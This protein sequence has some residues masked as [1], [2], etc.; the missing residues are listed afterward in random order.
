[1]KTHQNIT[2]TTQALLDSCDMEYDAKDFISKVLLYSLGIGIGVGLIF[3]NHS[4]EVSVVTGLMMFAGCIL[5]VYFLLL[6]TANKRIAM[7]ED[8]LPDFLNYVA[9]NI[10]SG[11][12]YDRALL[13]S[14]GKEFGPLAKEIDRAAKETLS[15]KT[16]GEALMEMAQRV[17]S[18]MF[19]KTIRLIVE[20]VN[21]GG[22]LA[23][24]LE[25]TS[26]DIRKFSAI[27][28]DVAATV[29]IYQL[30]IFAAAA[31]GA[32]LLYAVATFLVTIV[33]EMKS[34]MDISS[35]S[36]STVSLPFMR[37]GQTSIS[38]DLLFLFSIIAIA[39]T[40]FFGALASG[41]ISKGKE[42]DGLSNVPTIAFVSYAVFFAVRFMLETVVR[43]MLFV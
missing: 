5:S 33:S 30:F 1:M 20:G 4:L 26:S 39:I 42:S 17:D 28:K 23:Q 19:C 7:I 12:T 13:L 32:P 37:A 27:R 34:K 40:T 2:E 3:S 9:S 35:L 15:G 11:V 22:D 14:A 18:E 38:P 6:S 16:L 21:S 24:L 43:G 10:R 29:M 25:N 31:I 36:G 41:V 8:S